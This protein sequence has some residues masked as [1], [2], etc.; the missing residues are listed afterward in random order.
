RSWTVSSPTLAQSSRA[1]QRISE[2]QAATTDLWAGAGRRLRAQT[3]PGGFDGFDIAQERHARGADEAGGARDGD[4]GSPAAD[5]GHEAV[6]DLGH[7]VGG[8]VRAGEIDG[9]AVGDEAVGCVRLREEQLT[10]DAV[11]D[12]VALQGEDMA[13]EI[14]RPGDVLN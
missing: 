4:R 12:K 6:I 13:R 1:T 3:C 5:D 2:A 11:S 14:V 10:L 7:P 9:H 8:N